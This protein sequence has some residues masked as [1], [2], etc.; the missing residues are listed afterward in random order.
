MRDM[1]LQPGLKQACFRCGGWHELLSATD[2]DDEHPHASGS[3]Y[4]VCPG[5]GQFK[6]GRYFAGQVGTL[7]KYALRERFR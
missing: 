5:Y 7:S 2:E 3:L 1:T 4:V 6:P